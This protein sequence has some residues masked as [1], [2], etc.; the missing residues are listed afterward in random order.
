M[1]ASGSTT[2][3]QELDEGSLRLAPLLHARGLRRGAT[4]RA[5]GSRV[6]GLGGML[7]AVIGRAREILA[8]LESGHHVAGIT[9]P[10]APDAGQLALFEGEHPV[11]ADL[12]GLDP[13]TLTPLEAL[14]RLAE[15]KRQAEHP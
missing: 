12:R 15:L 5:Y 10:P 6:A 4:D 7:P 2:T 8:L 3:Y 1:A 13:N 9:P 14:A 11:L